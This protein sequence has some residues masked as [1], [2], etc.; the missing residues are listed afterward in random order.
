[1][2]ISRAGPVSTSWPSYSSSGRPIRPRGWRMEVLCNWSPKTEKRR[3]FV[4]NGC[5]AA[6][7]VNLLRLKYRTKSIAFSLWTLDHCWKRCD[8]LMGAD[9]FWLKKLSSLSRI[10]TVLSY[11]SSRPRKFNPYTI[12]L[13]QVWT[14]YMVKG[15]INFLGS[16]GNTLYLESYIFVLKILAKN[17]SEDRKSFLLLW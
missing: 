10:C 7:Q 11:L 13:D 5:L 6:I 3:L 16:Q 9:T 17:Y 8:L 15:C 2:P 4:N 12:L 1:M 14:V